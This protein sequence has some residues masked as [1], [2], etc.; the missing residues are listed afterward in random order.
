MD[1]EILYASNKVAIFAV[2]GMVIISEGNGRRVL[3]TPQLA[4]DLAENLPRFAGIAEE[5]K[6]K[7]TIPVPAA[8]PH[9]LG[10]VQ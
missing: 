8:P 1:D 3:L 7:A 4:R 10:L 6:V 5:L 9:A 2:K